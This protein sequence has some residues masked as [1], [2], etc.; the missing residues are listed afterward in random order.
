MLEGG[1]WKFLEEFPTRCC[2][3]WGSDLGWQVAVNWAAALLLLHITLVVL[4]SA[5]LLPS[6]PCSPLSPSLPSLPSLPGKPILPT[7]PGAPGAPGGPGGPGG[8]G[9]LHA[10]W[11]PSCSAP[12]AKPPRMWFATQGTVQRRRTAEIMAQP[13]KRRWDM[14]VAWFNPSRQLSTTQPLAHSPPTPGMGEK[15]RKKNLVS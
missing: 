15:I 7:V 6:S 5:F 2:L 1:E 12:L 11:G 4:R 9:R 13:V 14:A 8:P 10:S 3:S